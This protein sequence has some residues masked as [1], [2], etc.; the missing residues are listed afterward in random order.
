MKTQSEEE[1]G[2]RTEKED[3]EH[4]KSYTYGIRYG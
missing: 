1:E 2:Q 4:E 3:Q